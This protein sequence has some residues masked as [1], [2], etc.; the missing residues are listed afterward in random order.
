MPKLLSFLYKNGCD[1][2]FWSI[3]MIYTKGTVPKGRLKES[4]KQN[5]DFGGLKSQF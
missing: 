4:Q 2:H 3:L 1:A 5:L